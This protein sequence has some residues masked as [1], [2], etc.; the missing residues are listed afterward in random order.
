MW[1]PLKRQIGIIGLL[2]LLLPAFGLMSLRLV[3]TRLS[4][5]QAE[6]LAQRLEA[7][8]TLVTAQAQFD[9]SS[10]SSVINPFAAQRTMRADGYLDDWS[11][12]PQRGLTLEFGETSATVQSI[13]TKQHL[14]LSIRIEGH[15]PQRFF[16]S[17]RFVAGDRLVLRTE[18]NEYSITPNLSN[19]TSTR[20][21][22]QLL[23]QRISGYW[24]AMAT[25]SIIELRIPKDLVGQQLGMVLQ[26]AKTPLGSLQLRS[27]E[28][29]DSIPAVVWTN[30]EAQRLLSQYQALDAQA[31]IRLIDDNFNL[32][33]WSGNASNLRSP[34]PLNWL[35]RLSLATAKR[36]NGRQ[37]SLTSSWALAQLIGTLTINKTTTE[38]IHISSPAWPSGALAGLT[39]LNC[40]QP[41]C[42]TLVIIEPKVMGE[43]LWS[44][45]HLKL[46]AV[47][48][49]GA[50]VIIAV[51]SLWA[52]WLAKRLRRLEYNMVNFGR[53]QHSRQGLDEVSVLA[54]VFDDLQLQVNANTEY[55][56]QLANRLSHELRTPLTVIQSSLEHLARQTSGDSLVYVER[57]VRGSEQLQVIFQRI[58]EARNLEQLLLGV[59]PQRTDLNDLGHQVVQG[60][61]LAH[62]T[63]K[64]EF[65]GPTTPCFT[66]SDSDFL[67]QAMTKLIDNAISFHNE[68][69][70]IVVNVDEQPD[71]IRLS[72]TNEGPELVEPT[73][74]LF[75]AFVSMRKRDASQHLGFGLYLSKLICEHFAHQLFAENLNP[76]RVRFTITAEPLRDDEKLA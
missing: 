75:E 35:Q 52:R 43:I 50:I 53:Q 3:E 14:W 5:Y 10:N 1:I 34:E 56:E 31:E 37:L 8:T 48:F 25:G 62:P 21:R 33:A 67:A 4:E 2:L 47:L 6:T 41:S 46:I 32:L 65:Q 23:N 26:L 13:E 49:A 9:L 42:P 27:Y 76:G 39:R 70:C 66:L 30:S 71:A 7:L 58:T 45:G 19:E 74:Q 12:I 57:A 17:G 11:L 22:G 64:I 61:Q 68:G 60:Y 54:K 15:D 16:Q 63:L 20:E 73:K 44:A 36:P 69:S 40:N 72:V 24:K 29:A 18:F 55:L 38:V 59:T 28:E 51:I